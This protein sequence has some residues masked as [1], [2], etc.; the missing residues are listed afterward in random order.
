[1]KSV[2]MQ[3]ARIALS[4]IYVWFGLLKVMGESPANP[5]VASLLERTMPFVSF[6]TFIVWFGL[7]EV[8]IGVL[9]LIPKADRITLSLF[10]FHMVT[11]AMPLFLL[12]AIIWNKLFIP[13]LEG[14]YIIK[15]IALIALAAT[16]YEKRVR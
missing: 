15:N 12:P 5:L 2:S 9:F 10:V 11:T 6:E 13:T 3:F 16:I 14:Q 4:V 8:M 7:F 1:M